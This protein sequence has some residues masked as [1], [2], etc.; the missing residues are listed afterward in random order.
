MWR[1]VWWGGGD[2]PH[3]LRVHPSPDRVMTFSREGLVVEPLTERQFGIIAA[4]ATQ[5]LVVPD[6]QDTGV[7]VLTQ[8]GRLLADRL[9]IDLLT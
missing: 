5:G 8:K 1:R 9:A 7:V 3:L 4:A 2:G 6:W